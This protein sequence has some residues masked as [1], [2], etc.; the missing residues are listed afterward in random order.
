M[1][2]KSFYIDCCSLVDA[3]NPSN[4]IS[5]PWPPDAPTPHIPALPTPILKLWGQHQA[6]QGTPGPPKALQLIPSD[7]SAHARP[8]ECF[9]DHPKIHIGL[10]MTQK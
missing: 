7:D 4:V 8:V 1:S 9:E 2:R 3:L 10:N 5:P 6:E